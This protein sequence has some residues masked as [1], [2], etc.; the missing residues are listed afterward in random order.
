MQLK[1]VILN[2]GKFNQKNKMQSTKLT[3]SIFTIVDLHFAILNVY[4]H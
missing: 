2:F 1:P 3:L 4:F